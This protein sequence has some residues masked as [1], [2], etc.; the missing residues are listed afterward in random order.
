M[1][2]AEAIARARALFDVEAMTAIFGDTARDIETATDMAPDAWGRLE[3]A[4][5]VA[6]DEDLALAAQTF[7]EPD[8]NP[9]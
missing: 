8:Y 4:A 7:G 1:T 2:K 9:S 5:R 6:G 3:D